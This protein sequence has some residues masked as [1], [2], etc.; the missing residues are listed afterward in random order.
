[1]TGRSLRF[2]GPGDV[3]VE[4]VPVP[5]PGPEELLVRTDLSAISPGTERLVY[6]GE[7][8]SEVAVDESLPALT[9]E[10]TFSYPLRYGYQCVGEVTAAGDAVDGDWVGE[11]VV[12]FNPHESH[13]TALPSDLRR[14]PPARSSAAAALLPTAET[15][16][17]L[18]LDARPSL[19]ERVAVFGQGV[20]G[21]LTT[22]ALAAF[23]LAELVAVDPTAR[24]RRLAAEMGA[25]EALTP[26]AAEARFDPDGP[27][28]EGRDS[29]GTD[30]TLELSGNPEALDQA[31]AVTGFGGRV[32]VG[33]WYGDKPTEL[34]LGGRFH[35]SRI[36]VESSQVSTVAPRLRGRWDGERRIDVAWD[37]LGDV[38]V[39]RLVTH[40]I[41]VTEAPRAYELLADPSAY[42]QILLTYPD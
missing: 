34:D 21:L 4:E 35:R 15:A 37:R 8:P 33:S 27:G 24:R 1:M 11:T 38:D 16:V 19:G 7:V 12:A 10:G 25:H 26:E 42:V 23:P 40:R 17:N 39:G 32:V 41:P 28:A 14:V 30:L 22:A 6:R 36:S 13:F 18:V 29:G 31:V 5:D 20:V 3:V 9:A 2:R